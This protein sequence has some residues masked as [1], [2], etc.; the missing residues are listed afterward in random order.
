MWFVA[1][2]ITNLITGKHYV[3]I[4]TQTLARRWAGHCH[5]GARNLHR[6]ILKYGRENFFME[7]I[8]SSTNIEDLKALERLL[9]VQYDCLAPAGYNLTGGGDGGFN[10]A[11][12][13]RDRISASKR[14]IPRSQETRAKLAAALLGKKRGPHSESHKAAIAAAN[15]GFRHSPETRAKM[16]I[17]RATRRYPNRP[18]P[19]DQTIAKISASLTGK[20][21]SAETRAKMSATRTGR[22]GRLH[23]EADR[24]K[25]R[26]GWARRKAQLIEL[27]LTP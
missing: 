7:A 14:G 20:K 3:G 5:G 9:I 15:T 16:S 13:S 8:A 18:P 12:E 10:L 22:P 27:A 26:A 21:A 2:L 1:Y 19:S 25:M 17:E 11:Q 6:A 23:S 24:A 4:T